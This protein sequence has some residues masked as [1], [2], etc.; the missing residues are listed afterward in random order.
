M[1][2]LLIEDNITIATNIQKY[3]ELEHF[4]VDISHDGEDWLH[5]AKTGNYDLILLDIMLPKLNGIL[6]CQKIRTI[7]E[8][9]IIMLTAKGQLEDKVEWFWCGA[10][11]YLVKPFDLDELLLRIK[12]I[13]KRKN[14]FD[15]FVFWDIEV[16]LPTRKILKKGKEVHLSIKEFHILEYLIKN[17]GSAV[18]RTDIFEYV[19]WETAIWEENNK[20]DVYIANLRKKLDKHLITTIKW[21]GYTIEKK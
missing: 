13:M 21:Y 17:H 3:L 6:V 16:I 8:V 19:W 20:L 1:K 2:I 12:A 10:D 4:Q 18:S 11:D 7:S 9:P 14:K 5:K 15:T